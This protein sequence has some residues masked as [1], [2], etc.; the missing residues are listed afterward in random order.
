MKFSTR[1]EKLN[2]IFE[3]GRALRFHMDQMAHADGE[4][5]CPALPQ[6]LTGIQMKAALE[7][8]LHQPVSLGELAERLRVKPSAASVLVEKLVEKQVL[9]RRPDPEDRRRVVIQTH[10][11]ADEAMRAVNARFFHA[12][13]SIAGRVS[14][15]NVENWLKVMREINELLTK[16][17]QYDPS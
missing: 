17:S 13:N 1:E 4:G 9:T 3:T 16:E 7:V 6:D 8:F 14:E 10:P 15:R 11:R 12:F 5:P 2:F